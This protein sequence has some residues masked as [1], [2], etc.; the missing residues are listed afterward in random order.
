M[1][2]G[3]VSVIVGSIESKR[4]HVD[5]VCVHAMFRNPTSMTIDDKGRVLVVDTPH[6]NG[7]L[8]TSCVRVVDAGLKAPISLKTMAEDKQGHISEE[9]ALLSDVDVVVNGVVFKLH[10]WVLASKSSFFLKALTSAR[11]KLGSLCYKKPGSM[12]LTFL[13]RACTTD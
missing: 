2:N 13:P 5:S 1:K 6:K 11:R 10:A 4:G 9:L 3:L 8:K 12:F 7:Y